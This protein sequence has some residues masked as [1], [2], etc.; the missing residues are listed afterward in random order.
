MFRLDD[1]ADRPE[2]A[3]RAFRTETDSG[4]V[5]SRANDRY[6]ELAGGNQLFD[7]F[8]TYLRADPEK[9]APVT[10]AESQSPL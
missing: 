5:E 4:L 7:A 8:R 10:V 9:F 3:K 2:D 1:I 6:S